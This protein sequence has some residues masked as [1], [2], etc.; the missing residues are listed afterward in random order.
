MRKTHQT[1][2]FTLSAIGAAASAALLV[3]CGGGTGEALPTTQA[4]AERQDLAVKVVDGPVL[5]ALV[6]LDIN[7]NG[8]C[9]IG[10]PQGRTDA[11]GQVL[12]SIATDDAGKFPVIAEVGTDAVDADNGPV[13]S[14]YRMVAPSDRAGLISPLTTMVH[15][16]S[17]AT[18]SNTVDAAAAVQAL[19]GIADALA[20]YT[21]ASAPAVAAPMTRRV[22]TAIVAAL[23]AQSSALTGVAGQIDAAGS[24]MTAADLQLSGMAAVHRMLP[25][26]TELASAALPAD[27]SA[28]DAAARTLRDQ[29]VQALVAVSGLSASNVGMAVAAS[30]PTASSV[31][32]APEA[33]AR[34][35][36]FRYGDAE[37]WSFRT[38]LSNAAENT[39]ANQGTTRY[40]ELRQ[41]RQGSSVLSWAGLNDPNRRD[42]QHWSG[43]GWT[44]CQTD[45]QGVNSAP[46]AAGRLTSNYCDNRQVSVSRCSDMA[47]AGKSFAEVFA[48][49]RATPGQGAGFGD[50]PAGFSG[51]R[52]DSLGARTWPAGAN[53]RY[54]ASTPLATA[55]TYDLRDSNRVLAYGAEIT[56]GGDARNGSPA[57]TSVTSANSA[58]LLSVASTL[59]S[60]VQRMGGTPC[61]FNRGTL[62][63]ADG[64]RVDS[65][66]ANDWWSNSTLSLGRVGSAPVR[67][68]PYAA[69]YTTNK[70][71]RV[72]FGPDGRADYYSCRERA[73][74][75][76]TR[77]CV[78]TGSGIYAI[79]TLGDARLMTLSGQPA[80]LSYERV[81]V[82]RAGAVYYGYQNKLLAYETR[83]LNLTALNALFE[84]SGMPALVP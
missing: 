26:I 15:A 16:Q 50:A 75:G 48:M 74:D 62:S 4:L 18:G 51:K 30:R 52:D 29:Q 65:G 81:F 55:P 24:S 63:N 53:L 60:L 32:A 5:N 70:L 13:V 33:G 3:A 76:S 68:S 20:D 9:D 36:Q 37:N 49:I 38:F 77:N 58:S 79:S 42:E 7:E 83:R 61:R 27:G 2:L 44:A 45:T 12:I 78:A 71:L 11:G 23:Q 56:A 43:V 59:E 10:E 82:E 35:D 22:A 67:A 25:A 66:D 19:T 47:I 69:Y 80:S 73:S 57:C 40:R 6:C 64:S 21:L 1:R 84:A 28:P 54:Q 8:A 39:P 72:A 46:D 34:L 14:T 41:S 31:A 17:Q